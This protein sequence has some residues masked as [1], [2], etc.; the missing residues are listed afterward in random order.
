MQ[1]NDNVRSQHNIVEQDIFSHYKQ[2]VTEPQ[3]IACMKQ[4]FL[5]DFERLKRTSAS[6]PIRN[7]SRDPKSD[8]EDDFMIEEASVE[9]QSIEKVTEFLNSLPTKEVLQVFKN[10][11][12]KHQNGVL[13]AYFSY[14]LGKNPFR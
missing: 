13:K 9:E 11:N 10:L 2:I 6:K 1:V 14:V 12:T 3:G 5:E 4:I 7:I 8:I